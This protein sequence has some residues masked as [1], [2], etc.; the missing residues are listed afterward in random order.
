MESG[1]NRREKGLNSK[2]EKSGEKVGS[3]I[4]NLKEFIVRVTKP[5]VK[6]ESKSNTYS[7][8]K[9]NKYNSLVDES[10]T[11]E[12]DVLPT[13]VGG[14]E[15]LQRE[16]SPNEITGGLS[17]RNRPSDLTAASV[18]N[19]PEGVLTVQTTDGAPRGEIESNNHCEI[20]GTPFMDNPFRLL[21]EFGRIIDD[22][23]C[24][25]QVRPTDGKEK[26]ID[27]LKFLKSTNT[28]QLDVVKAVIKEWGLPKKRKNELLRSL[29][30]NE[31]MTTPINVQVK[32]AKKRNNKRNKKEGSKQKRSRSQS[33]RGVA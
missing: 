10:S 4:K 2:G 33:P 5:T 3:I 29:K 6:E 15:I 20:E 25:Q 23:E 7:S 27:C 26:M 9:P 19:K 28:T 14:T 31:P 17:N 24:R 32:G 22:L 13:S 30:L 16:S 21:E 18:D 12:E 11:F 1:F 8:W